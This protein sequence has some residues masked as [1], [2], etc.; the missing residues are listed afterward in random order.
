ME[1]SISN[2]PNHNMQEPERAC[3]DCGQAFRARPA[4]D[5]TEELCDFCYAAQFEQTHFTRW[6]KPARRTR[7][8]HAA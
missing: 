3:A 4:G 7:S 1:G 8:P 6:Q 5:G 2:F